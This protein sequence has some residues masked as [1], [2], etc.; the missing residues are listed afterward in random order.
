MLRMYF[1]VQRARALIHFFSPDGVSRGQF[2]FFS[3]DS[4]S[5]L[6]ARGKKE[7]NMN[8]AKP[9]YIGNSTDLTGLFF[10]DKEYQAKKD[11]AIRKISEETDP[12]KKQEKFL[13]TK[14]QRD[15][16]LYYIYNMHRQ[17]A[18]DFNWRMYSEWLHASFGE[19]LKISPAALKSCGKT[20]LKAMNVEEEFWDFQL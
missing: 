17:T 13:N 12:K 16:L 10:D 4:K 14:V 7:F 9:D 15:L 3:Y 5:V 8:A 11:R 6:F 2:K 19:R 20:A 18:S 1:A